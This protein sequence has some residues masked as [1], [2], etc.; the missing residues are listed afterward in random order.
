MIKQ[1]LG[2]VL[3]HKAILTKRMWPSHWTSKEIMIHFG[4]GNPGL[5]GSSD[6][7]TLRRS[8]LHKVSPGDWV[9]AQRRRKWRLTGH[10]ARR[11]DGRWSTAVLTWSPQ[12]GHRQRGHPKK[13]WTHDFD[14][15]FMEHQGL[16]K[17][18]WTVVAQNRALWRSFEDAFIA[19]AWYR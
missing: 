4:W 5:N 18:T 6:A 17:G 15:F 14:A 19:Q 13:R 9:T 11:T 10:T 2:K 1:Q 7:H 3:K 12:Q 8:I 16:P